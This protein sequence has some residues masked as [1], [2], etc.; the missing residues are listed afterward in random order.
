MIEIDEP[1]F[2]NSIDDI[3]EFSAFVQIYV[4][5]TIKYL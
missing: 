2:L 1:F 5:I 4:T 3:F